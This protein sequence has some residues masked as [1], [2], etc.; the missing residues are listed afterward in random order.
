MNQEDILVRFNNSCIEG[1]IKTCK[2]CWWQEGGRCYVGNPKRNE[3]GQSMVMAETPCDKYW[4]KRQALETAIP[5]N[6]L[7]ITG[8]GKI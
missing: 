4:N 2:H 3:H 8:E 7:V 5:S 6:M 1:R